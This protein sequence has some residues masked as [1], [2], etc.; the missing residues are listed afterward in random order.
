MQLQFGLLHLC[1]Q[2]VMWYKLGSLQQ[3]TRLVNPWQTESRYLNSSQ[4]LTSHKVTNLEWEQNIGIR[5]QENNSAGYFYSNSVLITSNAMLGPQ[6]IKLVFSI[7]IQ[8]ISPLWFRGKQHA[9]THFDH[10]SS[11]HWDGR[12]HSHRKSS[13]KSVAFIIFWIASL[14]ISMI[15]QLCWFLFFLVALLGWAK[16]KAINSDHRWTIGKAASLW[17]A[18]KLNNLKTLKIDPAS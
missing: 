4:A 13:A 16:Y 1:C 17:I 5:T 6:R 18:L 15:A 10:L 11:M 3:N 9:L 12:S 7:L 2:H 8:L 14:L